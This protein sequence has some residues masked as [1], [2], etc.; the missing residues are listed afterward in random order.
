MREGRAAIF[1]D[2]ATDSRKVKRGS[3][4]VALKGEKFDGHAFLAEAVRRGAACLLVHRRAG[5]RFDGATVINVP[6][7]LHALGEMAHYRRAKFAPKILAITGSNGKTTT[8][9]MVASILQRASLDGRPLRGRVLKT[10]GNFNNLV[11]LPLTLLGLRARE[12]VAVLE[13]GT[14]RPGEIGR[15]AEIADPDIGLITSIAPAHLSG[16]GSLAGVAREKGDL[17]RAM[18]GRGIAVINLDDVRIRRLGERFKGTKITYGKNGEVRAESLKSLG[19]RSMEFT[20]R[21]GRDE[22]RIRL[23]LSGEHNVANALG[24]AAMA[25]GLGVD[26]EAVR[27]GL[28]AVRP[29]PMRMEIERWKGIGIINDAYNA[30]PASVEAA[31]K[32]LAQ[33]AGR[34][35]RVVVLGDMLEL[36]SEKR[37]RHLELGQKAARYRVDRLYLFGDQARYVKEGALGAGMEEERVIVGRSHREIARRIRRHARKEDWLLFK[38]SRGMQMD[39]VLAALKE[40]GD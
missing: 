39:K 21:A 18:D 5:G 3:L 4:F 2:V 22:R 27:R 17:F 1:S 32:T 19:A 15:L 12:R 10:E 13:M 9:E 36:G 23:N 33:M 24:A 28:E 30:N 26:L 40:T 8:K 14:S 35:R 11:G 37:R 25:Y 6:D 29:F 7:T 20:L 31:L 34:G 16:L 38:G